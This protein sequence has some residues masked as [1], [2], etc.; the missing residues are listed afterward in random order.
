[1]NCSH[2][3]TVLLQ[4]LSF[5][6]CL[7]RSLSRT[8]RIPG[9]WRFARFVLRATVLEPFDF[10]VLLSCVRSVS[11]GRKHA[12]G[13]KRLAGER[14][15]TVVVLD[16][17]DDAIMGAL[18]AGLRRSGQVCL[19]VGILWSCGCG[20]LKVCF[21]LSFSQHLLRGLFYLARAYTRLAAPRFVIKDADSSEGTNRGNENPA[22]FI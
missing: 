9:L 6:A 20:D 14:R 2:D 22:S 10:P 7:G 16:G 4:R 8:A 15:E 12:K 18:C 17:I 13:V 1:M 11:C 5:L 3:K 21:L 19:F